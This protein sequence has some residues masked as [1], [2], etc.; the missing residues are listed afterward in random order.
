MANFCIFPAMK[1][2]KREYLF[3][4]GMAIALLTGIILRFS[5]LP[6]V[7]PGIWYDEVFYC[8]EAMSFLNQK[9]RLIYNIRNE[10]QIGLFPALLAFGFLVFGDTI[11]APRAVMAFFGCLS[12]LG[13][14]LLTLELL[15][16]N[17]Y[18][19]PIT[20]LATFL[21]ATSYWHLNFSRLIFSASLAPAF[22]VFSLYFTLRAFRYGD[23]KT[24]IAAAVIT[25][26]GFYTYWQYYPYAL[27]PA[28]IALFYLI[29]DPAKYKKTFWLYTAACII[30]IT[31]L[32]YGFYYN[33]MTGRL[34]PLAIS[35]S[36]FQFWD[37]TVL[38]IKML[39]MNGYGDR[40][41]RHNLSGNAGLAPLAAFGVISA[42]I[43]FLFLLIGGKKHRSD[44]K[45][46]GLLFIWC[47]LAMLP[48]S[49]SNEGLPHASRAVGMIIALQ[50]IAAMGVFV[51][52]RIIYIMLGKVITQKPA[53]AVTCLVLFSLS[54]F[55]AICT[56]YEYFDIFANSPEA[57]RAF[58]APNQKYMH[59]NFMQEVVQKFPH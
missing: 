21:L 34:K 26:L 51:V 40:N 20:V 25:A 54:A 52:F 39:F 13:C 2:T 19:K 36:L 10:A 38:H 41:W 42:S 55:Q 28:G 43:Y 56:K 9:I 46:L 6:L 50:I 47:L 53:L 12:L 18:K 14:G 45:V 44:L 1:T 59:Y 35:F 24:I 3:F 11:I 49:L 16:D 8:D 37:N 7:P 30:A 4:G 48:A 31:P 58:M 32:I 23:A 29:N 22:E 15:K 27:I 33:D 17:K 57:K 5:A